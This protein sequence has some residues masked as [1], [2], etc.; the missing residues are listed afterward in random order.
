MNQWCFLFCYLKLKKYHRLIQKWIRK[1]HNQ[2]PTI[3]PWNCKDGLTRL[4]HFDPWFWSSS[5]WAT[6]MSGFENSRPLG[7]G[8]SLCTRRRSNWTFSRL[9]WPIHRSWIF[10]ILM[11]LEHCYIYFEEIKRDER[12][13]KEEKKKIGESWILYLTK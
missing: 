12:R 5:A 3:Y 1:A 10:L 7:L 6:S 8:L 9:G 2:N 4:A 13:W 11:N